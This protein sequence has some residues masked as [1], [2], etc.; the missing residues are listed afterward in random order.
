MDKVFGKGALSV[1]YWVALESIKYSLGKLF[2][3]RG[4][5]LVGTPIIEQTE[6]SNGK[7][8]GEWTLQMY[9]FLDPGEMH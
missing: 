1:N 8:G 4:Y 9:S 7:G 6:L 2:D 5:Q 3:M